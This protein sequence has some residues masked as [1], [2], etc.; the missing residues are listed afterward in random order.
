MQ[1]IYIPRINQLKLYAEIQVIYSWSVCKAVKLLW[2]C[3]ERH[4]L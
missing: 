2:Y 1:N 4:T 3:D